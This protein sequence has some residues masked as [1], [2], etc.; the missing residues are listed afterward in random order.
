LL[1]PPTSTLFPYHDALP[2][3]VYLS[4]DKVDLAKLLP[5][6][7]DAQ[8]LAQKR[9]LAAVL[10]IQQKRT[11]EQTKRAIA[12]NELSIFRFQDVLGPRSE[13]HTS[14]LQSREKLVCR[15]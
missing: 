12:D 1:R 7:P 3:F 14:E 15:L 13:E 8:S 11:P 9:D 6:P 5:P 10:E 2:I 4:Q